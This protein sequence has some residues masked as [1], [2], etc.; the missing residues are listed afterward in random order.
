MT[1]ADVDGAHIRLLLLTFL[2]RYCRQLLTEDGGRVYIACPPLY[3]VTVAGKKSAG[4]VYLYD[5][6]AYDQHIQ[7]L[8]K[9]GIAGNSITTQRFKGLGEMMPQQLW[10]TTMDPTR[11]SLKLV[12]VEDAAAADR[13]FSALMGD[14]V[15]P[16]KEF[17]LA[18]AERLNLSDLD[19]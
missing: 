18:N 4:A 5:Q 8:N 7:S 12:A 1:D 16:R 9:Q 2:Y 14:N 13:L 6:S 19:Y 11:R 10:E 15:A 3:K 17:I